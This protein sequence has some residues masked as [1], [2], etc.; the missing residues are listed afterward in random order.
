MTPER[1]MT[2]QG[3]DGARR[4][5]MSVLALAPSGDLE[6]A[7][8]ALPER[9]A[10]RFVRRPEIGLVMVRARAGGSGTRFNLGEM[11]VSRCTVA[12]PSGAVG[13]ACIGGRRPRHAELA[14]VFDGLLQDPVSRPRL[15]VSLVGP[16]EAAER[17]R[18][19]TLRARSEPTRVEF[20]TLVRGED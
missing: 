13:Q 9:P 6:A 3:D 8:S 2:G 4:R 17:L 20:F 12:L 18:R 14:A 5:W 1:P 19:E 7:W 11:T 16:L 10:Y 15:E